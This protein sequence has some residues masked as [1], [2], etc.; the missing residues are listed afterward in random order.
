[1]KELSELDFFRHI[2]YSCV[3]GICDVNRN[4]QGLPQ[5]WETKCLEDQKNFSFDSFKRFECLNEIQLS[6]SSPTG[7]QTF[8]HIPKTSGSTFYDWVKTN[9]PF[10]WYKPKNPNLSH[11]TCGRSHCSV[12]EVSDCFQPFSHQYITIIRNPIG[13]N[14][15]NY[16]SRNIG[17]LLFQKPLQTQCHSMDVLVEKCLQS[18]I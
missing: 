13:M 1:M 8:I 10:V 6:V 7:E 5:L 9:H 12:A 16:R 14:I 2:T 18:G 11:E 4:L 3:S 15:T 17:I